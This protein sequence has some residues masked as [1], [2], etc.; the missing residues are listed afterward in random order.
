[1]TALIIISAFFILTIIL[2][3]RAKQKQKMTL[4]NWAVGNRSFN[5]V[6]VFLLTAGEV[7]TTF[8]FLGGS[9]WTYSKGISAVYVMV[10]I[11]LSYVS[12][13]FLLPLIWSYANKH[14]L[15]SQSDFFAKKYDSKWLGVIV[16]LV[17]V[18]AIVP[19]IV[20]QLKGL[21]I[22]VSLTSYGKIPMNTAIIIGTLGIILYSVL[23]GIRGVAW[24]SVLKDFMILFVIVFMGIYL[25][26][27]YFGSYGE[28]FTQVAEVKPELLTFPKTTYTVTWFISTVL[29]YVLGFYMWPQVFASTFTAKNANTFRKNAIISPIYTLMLL[30]VIFIGFTAVIKVPGLQ[31]DESDLALIQLAIDSF[32]PF[33]VGIIGAAG[34]LTAL[35]PGSML[36]MTASTL[37]SKNI[38]YGLKEG[39]DEARVARL[40]KIFVPILGGLSCLFVFQGGN[41]LAA[42]LQVGYSLI[43]QLCPALF[44]SL[45]KRNPVTT[46]GA[47]SGIV[48]GILITIF[49]SNYSM[50]LAT[51]FPSLPRVI[52]DINIGFLPLLANILVTF[53]VSTFTRKTANFGH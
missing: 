39:Y 47:I 5:T 25:P 51:I 9:G 15:V 30:F 48:T 52:S 8:S 23:S 22:I 36:L 21:G 34:M 41:A 53:M 17:G 6:F 19:I 37:F 38:V 49:I 1:M 16:A 43:V 18:I 31:G 20:I 50:T 7:Y 11:A 4:E 24:I 2:A 26:L 13:Y 29:F 33:F 46:A 32:N 14:R 28:L 45:M 44:A 3:I 12:S 42:I 27:H 10:Y 35:V 40:S